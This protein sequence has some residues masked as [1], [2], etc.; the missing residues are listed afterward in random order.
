MEEQPR[1]HAACDAH[2]WRSV[3][4]AIFLPFPT[5]KAAKVLKGYVGF[6]RRIVKERIHLCS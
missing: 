2:G 5:G 4:R 6:M 3:S 1:Q